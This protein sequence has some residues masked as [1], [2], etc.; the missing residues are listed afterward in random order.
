M[1]IRAYSVGRNGMPERV[2]YAY[3]GTGRDTLTGWLAD[4]ELAPY[5]V[6]YE[7]WI[8]DFARGSS[9]RPATRPCGTQAA[10]R[11]H[12]RHGEDPCEDCRRANA[13][14]TQDRVINAVRRERY[15]DAIAAGMS[16]EEAKKM[17]SRKT[18]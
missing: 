13:R 18:A 17:R 3:R 4:A 14:G 11:R 6:E 16:P 1:S 2:N 12:K 8:P 10:Y 5:A 7:Q 15:R 9:G